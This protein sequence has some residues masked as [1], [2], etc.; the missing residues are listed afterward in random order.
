MALTEERGLAGAIGIDL[1]VVGLEQCEAVDLV[2]DFAWEPEQL[3]ADSLFWTSK[4]L[5][6]RDA[7]LCLRL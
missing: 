5:L 3:V 4:A 2:D 6:L 1:D 7:R